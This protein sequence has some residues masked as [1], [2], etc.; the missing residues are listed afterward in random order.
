M[1]LASTAAFS[2]FLLLSAG[3]LCLWHARTWRHFDRSLPEGED[4]DFRYRQF[5]RRMQTSGMLGVLGLVI[6]VGRLL[7]DWIVPPIWITLWW[8]GVLVVLAWLTLLALV[9]IWATRHHFS[10]LRH[11]YLLEEV[12]LRAEL[13]RLRRREGNG[14]H[15]P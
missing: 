9:D 2:A 7:I 11:H 12:K 8:I 3:G 6:L 5:R 14:R 4:R 10:R 13:E 15:R 1:D